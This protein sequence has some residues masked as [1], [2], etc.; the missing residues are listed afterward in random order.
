[1]AFEH[2]KTNNMLLV[3]IL[4]LIIGNM[5]SQLEPKCSLNSVSYSIVANLSEYLE[6]EKNID[7]RDIYKDPVINKLKTKKIGT[8]KE[9]VFNRSKFDN[10]KE[11]DS[12]DDLIKD[13]KSRKLDGLVLNEGYAN[14]TQ[15]LTDDLSRIEEPVDVIP[16]SFGF[17][18][19][20]K[21]IVNSFND[22][23]KTHTDREKELK[24]WKGINYGIKSIEEEKKSLTGENGT[25]NALFRLK[26]EPYAYKDDNGKVTGMEVLMIYDFAKEKGY[27]VNLKEANTYEELIESLKNKSADVVGGLLP[28][29]EGYRKEI[30]YSNITHS[31]SNRLVVRYE[32]LNDSLTWSQPYESPDDLDGKK[33]GVLKGS[34]LEELTSDNFPEST[35][36][37]KENTFDLF[38]GLMMDEFEGFLMDKPNAEY[39]KSEYP[40]R[41]T[42]FPDSYYDTEYGF[43]FQKNDKGKNLKTE[44][45]NYLKSINFQEIYNKW[46]TRKTSNLTIDKKLNETAELIN[47]AFLPNVRP[48]CFQEDG[49]M[50]GAEI[51]LLYKFAKEKNYNIKL[52]PI[53]KV[54][55]RI[56]SI[57]NG[58]ANITGGYLTITD[59]RKEKVDFSEP[60][61]TAGTVM[62]VRKDSKKDE[63]AIKILDNKYNLKKNNT[64]DILVKF[65]KRVTN[66]S[67]V[68]PEKYNETITINCTI[69]DLK[70]IDPY[71]EGF[72]YVNSSDKI[73]ITYSKLDVGNFIKANSKL[74]GH[75]IITESDKSKKVCNDTRPSPSPTPSPSPSPSPTPSPVP[76]PSPSPSDANITTFYKSQKN[77][78][79]LPTGG[80]IAIMIPCILLLL[81]AAAF[82]LMS[83]RPGAIAANQYNNSE[84]RKVNMN[85]YEVKP[86]VQVVQPV[87]SVQAIKDVTV[88]Q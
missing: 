84:I 60:F 85:A 62:V 82:A 68:F 12:L 24:R 86:P 64:A 44:F 71:N 77:S 3:F 30:S 16:Y 79:G 87:E 14:K 19:D 55:E 31:S 40:N 6:N 29:K 56:S 52:T 32:N 50:K 81:A 10:I 36:I 2:F 4:A 72:E 59:E 48:F 54:E 53:D 1:M 88:I 43:A 76:S 83:S 65:P 33:L 41:I 42:Y 45:N 75:K 17:Q 46:N 35:L 57:E 15:F 58:K 8:M 28:I 63:V 39:F 78:S 5:N 66:S 74:K 73:G 34:N 69:S 7:G 47:A 11:Y 70:D 18:K 37:E 26:N 61:F 9:L 25:I 67:C 13:L 49:E 80:I 27:A 20:N 22:F 23:L 51:E 21:T 38:E